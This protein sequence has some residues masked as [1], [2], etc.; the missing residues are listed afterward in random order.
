[1]T[2]HHRELSYL[3][4]P[5]AASYIA[6]Q[7][8]IERLVTE[9]ALERLVP[10][11]EALDAT[12]S[13]RL[14]FTAPAWNLLWWKHYQR[15][16]RLV[17]D[18]LNSY[19]LR[20]ALGR[21]IAVAPM[22][23][24]RRAFSPVQLCELQFFGADTNVTEMRG[25]IARPEHLPAVIAALQAEFAAR[26]DG[27]DWVQWRGLR[28]TPGAAP[29]DAQIPGFEPVRQVTDYYLVL[30]TSWTAFKTTLPRNIKESLRK[31]YN[32][33]AR[34]GHEFVFRAVTD[35]AEIGAAIERFLALH[36][37]R[38]ELMETIT[39]RNSFTA[40]QSQAFLHDY[41]R[42][43]AGRQKFCVFELMIG[44]QVVASRV[45]MLLGD[46]IFLYFSGYDPAWRRY[47]VMTTL[48]AEALQWAIA[49]GLRVANLSS[50][51]DVSK[52]RWR[53]ASVS[54]TDGY[55][56]APGW[57]SGLAFGLMSRL[58]AARGPKPGATQS[59]A[60]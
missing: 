4:R 17:G 47:S 20:N 25:V 60:A 6:G 57:R 55:A 8:R 29:W 9:Q 36:T 45:A 14:P 35:P 58:R 53:P 19:A 1:M 41:A 46:E 44:G 37:R 39:H 43:A 21:L 22:M 34:D 42:H 3:G 16:Q 15:R 24:T 27:W 18:R 51:T 49:R 40:P 11:W 50:G 26:P 12:L 56:V 10:E 52:T 54:Y 38:A 13:P 5:E 48:L 7:L 59:E 23:I 30:P 33:L 28:N 31:C 2:A 32:S